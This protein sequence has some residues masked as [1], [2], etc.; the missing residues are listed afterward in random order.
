MDFPEPLIRRPPESN[1]TSRFWPFVEIPPPDG[2]RPR[3]YG[4]LPPIRGAMTGPFRTRFDALAFAAEIR[5]QTAVQPG[6][7]PRSARNWSH[8]T[9]RIP[10]IAEESIRAGQ[11]PELAGL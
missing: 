11:I 7:H 10:R 8:Q 2:G 3:D 5:T 9:P 1:A 4:P 6:D